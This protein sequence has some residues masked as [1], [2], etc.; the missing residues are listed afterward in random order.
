MKKIKLFLLSSILCLGTFGLTSCQCA[1]SNT[2]FET[3]DATC[4]EGEVKTTICDDC[5]RAIKNEVV[6]DPLGHDYKEETIDPTKYQ[7]GYTLHKCSRCGDEWRDT[8]TATLMTEARNGLNACLNYLKERLKDPNSIL[9]EATCYSSANI[10]NHEEKVEWPGYFL[11]D[12][13]YNAKNGFGGYVGY[14]HLYFGWDT[15]YRSVGTASY[16]YYLV[17]KYDFYFTVDNK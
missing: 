9:Y 5:G 2:H 16:S 3:K 14:R 6:S 11:Y 15:R 13:N 17:Y 8:P 10:N 12:I 1:H 7:E 4:T